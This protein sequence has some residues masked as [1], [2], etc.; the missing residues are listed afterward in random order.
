MPFVYLSAIGKSFPVVF[1]YWPRMKSIPMP[2]QQSAKM[3]PYIKAGQSGL[4]ALKPEICS[5]LA[6]STAD[7]LSCF[8]CPSTFSCTQST[9]MC[10]NAVSIAP[11][12][13][14]M[15]AGLLTLV[16]AVLLLLARRS[17]AGHV[18]QLA[19]EPTLRLLLPLLL[20]A[21]LLLALLAAAREVLDEI[22]VACRDVPE[23]DRLCSIA[24]AVWVG[25]LKMRV[26]LGFTGDG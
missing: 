22:H 8:P 20:L 6:C 21:L 18:V 19:H 4:G 16:E 25:M 2:C 3:H 5:S 17:A 10:G 1:L 7:S 9:P 12:C 26:Y 11:C 24:L 23:P 13:P 14:E 15:R